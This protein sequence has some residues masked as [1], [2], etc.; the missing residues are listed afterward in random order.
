MMAD[1]LVLGGPCV[2]GGVIVAER[3]ARA[4]IDAAGLDVAPGV[5]D[6]HGGAVARAI[7]ARPGV[8]LPVGIAFA[9]LEAQLLAAG[10]TT[11]YLAITLSWEAGLR[12]RATYEM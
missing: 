3:P 1:V 11:A 7:A 12:S 9:E 8:M 2:A 6:G 4:V 5:I 10:I